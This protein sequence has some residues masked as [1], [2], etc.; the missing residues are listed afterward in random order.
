M[1]RI[2]L[3]VGAALISCRAPSSAPEA[4]IEEASPAPAALARSAWSSFNAGDSSRALEGL[5]RAAELYAT[6]GQEDQELDTL[7]K[8]AIVVSEVGAPERAIE[9]LRLVL[10]RLD[11]LDLPELEG[12]TRVHTAR[13]QTLIGDFAA[14]H[15]SLDQA[16][17]NYQGARSE[18]GRVLVVGERGYTLMSEGRLP[19]AIFAGEEAIAGAER[20]GLKG[21]SMRAKS[22]V[23]YALQQTGNDDRARELYL[24]LRDLAWQNNHQRLLQFVYCNLAEIDW[25]Q[26]AVRP[27]EADLPSTLDALEAARA[28][29]PATPEERA[30]FLGRQVPAY[31]RLIRL[32]AD[33]YRGAEGFA[34]AERFH[35]LSLLEGLRE[36]DLD[37]AAVDLPELRRE[38][39][40]LLAE[41]GA[42]RLSLDDADTEPARAHERAELRRLEAE[43]S[44]LRIELRQQNPR[45]S[46]LV[47][48][49]P[50]GPKQVQAGLEQGETLVAYWVSEQRL[51]AWALTADQAHFIE[52]PLPRQR[53]AATVSRYL[54]PLRSLERADDLA[55]KGQEA[56]HIA[57]GRD[58]YDWLIAPIRAAIEAEVL[59]IVPDDLLHHLP[60]ESLIES[61]EPRPSGDTDRTLYAG[62][63]DCRFLGTEKAIA[64]NPS[65]GVF[66]ELRQRAEAA[67]AAPSMLAMAPA[68]S[69]ERQ[70]TFAA[71]F[72]TRGALPRRPLKHAADEAARVA[73]IF[74]SGTG[75]VGHRATE[76]RFKAEA[77]RHRYLHLATHGLVDDATPM[78][79]G[80]L[81]EPGDGE[82]GLLQAHEVLGLRLRSQLV[83]LSACRS[84]RGELSRGEGIVGLARAFLY[85]GASSVL[86]SQWDV[87]DRSTSDLMVGFYRRLS[88]GATRA[89][90]LRAA[91]AD[92][93]A[94]AGETRIAFRRRPV[95]YAHPRYWSAFTLIGAP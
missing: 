51:L 37:S 72:A 33:T 2:L 84:G 31:D 79:S 3:I 57:A 68:F 9:R 32:L 46:N 1:L 83:T 52:I 44:A 34:V 42:L 17:A 28:V 81:L 67:S 45:Y 65:A 87:D 18:E 24:E 80:L 41:L 48:L 55:L 66:L 95:A 15:A 71:A 63:R 92:L 61:C 8:A 54:S 43:L 13:A 73:G 11:A 21:E 49:E 62:Y 91:R 22:V 64:Y 88:A 27:A 58:L 50:P 23:A 30:A 39:R 26:G 14:A 56:E 53:L 60:F 85:A 16:Y 70:D 47:V 69:D 10:D 12:L 7:I 75:E 86:V 77:G 6:A 20:L 89:E 78:V 25:R 35:A 82:D 36:R 40:R 59:I 74:S 29:S 19:E 4:A 38:E 90:A 94:G 5:E 76:A 93:F